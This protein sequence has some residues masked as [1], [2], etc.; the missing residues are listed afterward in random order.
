MHEKMNVL[1]LDTSTDRLAI[2]LEVR[3]GVICSKTTYGAQKHGRDLIPCIAELL[4]MGGIGG[5][6]ID[7]IGVGLGPGSF[8]GLRVGVTAAKTLAY[9]T[10]APLVGM[11]SLLAVAWNAPGDALRVSV[12]ADAHA[13]TCT[14]PTS[15]ETCRESRLLLVR[16]PDRTAR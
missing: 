12:I 14:R 5:G 9:I 10:G 15:F 8:T 6:E 1:V 2:G 11:D 7:A 13:G 16:E 4:A 3:T